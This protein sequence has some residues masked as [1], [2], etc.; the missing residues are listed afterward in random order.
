MKLFL[1]HSSRDKALVRE[2]KSKLP[3]FIE[4]W[5][6]EKD[7]TVGAAL[8]ESINQAIQD[9]ADYVVVFFDREAIN[10]KWVQKEISWA[11]TREK[12]LGRIF[13]IPIL[14]DDSWKN[15]RPV[16][17]KKR[18]YLMCLDQSEFGI[19]SFVEKFTYQFFKLACERLDH[20][21]EAKNR[22][23][24]H[25]KLI[26]T[27]RRD[28]PASKHYFDLLENVETSLTIVGVSL[29]FVIGQS[30]STM[31]DLLKKNDNVRIDLLLFDPKSKSLGFIAKFA[32]KT[33]K[34]LKHE[35][36]AN[37]ETILGRLK[38]ELNISS[39]QRIKIRLY[40][41]PPIFSM[42]LINR[43]NKSK[44]LMLLEFFQYKGDTDDRVSV[45]VT[46]SS[47]IYEKYLK[48]YDEIFKESIEFKVN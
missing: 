2:I 31:L 29:N 7:L 4:T 30:L 10:S 11:M 14:L 37:L 47:V 44:S 9:E 15:I 33:M 32:N 5:L 20:L 45:E 34:S 27:S 18:F 43:E 46:T 17:F 39:L 1:S 16:S 41:S 8:E 19:K 12:E 6:D 36:N 28:M 24:D 38:E 22:I 42:T 26:Y 35:I 40:D 25:L 23:T 21:K 48:S 3:A 13:I